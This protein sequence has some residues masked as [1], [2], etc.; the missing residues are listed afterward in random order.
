MVSYQAP[1]V[2][3]QEVPGGSRPIEGIGTAV[4]AFVGFTE[5]GPV[6]EAVRVTNWTQYQDTFG[7]FIRTGYTPLAVYGFFM[8]GGGNCYVIRV[9]GDAESTPAQIALPGRGAAQESLRFTSKL[10]GSEGNELRI[11]LADEAA[12]AAEPAEGEEAPAGGGDGDDAGRFRVTIRA[13]GQPPEVF[14]NLS[15]RRGDDR[16]VETVVNA[17]PGGSMFVTVEDLAPRGVSIANRLP[18]AGGYALAEGGETVTALAPADFQGDVARREGIDGL[19]VL[20]DVTMI[21]LPDL[22][23]VYGDDLIN[24]DGVVSVQKG[25]IAHCERMQNR[26]AIVDSPPDLS[27]QEMEQWRNDANLV[28]DGGYAALYYPWIKVDDP[29]SGEAIFVPPSGDA[30]GDAPVLERDEPHVIDV[31]RSA[32]RIAWTE[33]PDFSGSGESDRHFVV[34]YR[35]GAVRFGPFIRACDGSGRQHGAAPRRGDTLILRSYRAGGGIV[36]NVG[37][38]A[39]VQLRSSVFYIAAVVNYRVARGGLDLESLD[40]AKLRALTVLRTTETAVTRDDYQQIALGV[41][42]VGR[43]YCVL[44]V[45]PGVVRV[46]LIPELGDPERPLEPE[47]LAPGRALIREVSAEL[48]ERKIVGTMIE[49]E[50][51]STSILEIDAHLFAE[52]GVDEEQ[53]AAA[54]EADLRR[55]LHPAAGG[56]RGQGWELGSAAT[57]SQ[58]AAR[59]QGLPG[60]A[61]VERVRLRVAGEETSRAEAPDDRPAG[62]HQLL[63][64]R[65]ARGVTHGHDRRAAHSPTRRAAA[66][67]AGCPGRRRQRRRARA[68]RAGRRPDDAEPA[69]AV[70]ARDLLRRPVH[71]PVPA[72]LRVHP[73]CRCAARP[74][75]FRSTST[76]RSLP[77]RCARCS[78]AGS[79]RRAA[80]WPRACRPRPGAA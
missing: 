74:L 61:F 55:F 30:A 32:E 10:P 60:V 26:V 63:R 3:I 6:G 5:K 59:L 44:D 39:I 25:L 51:V 16:Y 46:V 76:P 42:G 20:D 40:E 9:G 31:Q 77:T 33:V 4:A 58:I 80:R 2:Y 43:A 50:G 35:T 29:A 17:D 62:A 38:R 69:A 53:L 45:A 56:H 67:A 48:D 21:A 23:R 27:P 52:P 78:P 8:N 36:G 12:P 18:N 57:E 75:R 1:G 28:T 64:T 70:P 19:E 79:A 11:E 24:M 7:G 13:A 22:M 47:E 15:L 34:D 41:P 73:T 37:E 49:Y 71:R 14:E 72:H 68:G 54:A 66:G 65:R